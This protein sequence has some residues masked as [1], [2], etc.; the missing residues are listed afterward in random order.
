MNHNETF[1]TVES[2]EAELVSLTESLWETPELGLHETESAELLS[3]V[4]RDA[5]F[6]VTEGIGGMPTAFSATYG[7]GEPHVG[8]L[9]EYDALPGLSQ[10][11][12]SSRD[13]VEAGAPGHGCGHNLFGVAGVGAALAAKRAIDDGRAEGTVTFFGCP[14]EEILVGKVFMA[15]DGAF[16]DLDA[17]LTWH[18]SHLSA[19]FMAQTLAMNSVEYT[20]H[21]ESAHA[22]DSPQSGRSALDAVE[23]LNTGSE[24]MREHVSDDARIHYTIPD[25]GGAP[26]VVPAEATAWFYV[27]APTRDEVDRITDWLDDVAEGAAL[28]TQTTVS[29][30]FHTGCYD[31]VAN[32]ALSDKLLENMRLAGPIPYTDED[33]EFAA[34]LQETL[35]AETIEARTAQLPEERREAARSSVL[36]PDAQPSYD[37]GTVLNGSTDVG[38]VSWI[39]PTAQF[40]AASWP[41]GT[42]SHTWQAVA[43]NGSFGSKAAVYAAKVLAATTLDLL[44]DEALVAAAR[45]EFEASVPGE[46]ECALPEGMEPPFHLTL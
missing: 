38:D 4:L 8:I 17:A 10:T 16:D 27:R 9:G 23:L 35:S 12:S 6:D 36:Y 39:T 7:E 43:A 40:W 37:V 30:R 3:S 24:F 42:P 29:R 18:P 15:R 26:N 41:V 20:F 44:S 45:E 46:Y 1:E 19:P 5:G 34:E 28:M 2:L 22:A 13:P 32:H 21:G 11:V 31:Y 33:R 25:G 14:A